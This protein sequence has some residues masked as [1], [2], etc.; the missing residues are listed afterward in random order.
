M[1]FLLS[2][3]PQHWRSLKRE[4]ENASLHSSGSRVR[5]P[6]VRSV[7]R[8]GSPQDRIQSSK[9]ESGSPS[10]RPSDMVRREWKYEAH[11]IKG[12]P[13]LASVCVSARARSTLHSIGETF[14]PP[15][16]RRSLRQTCNPRQ[17]L[18]QEVRGRTDGVRRA[19]VL[20]PRSIDD[21]GGREGGRERPF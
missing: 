16:S 17:R 13:K 7:L 14:A 9:W 8:A 12:L 2:H 19:A 15:P 18:K 5:L 3:L 21:E 11:L 6:R 10:V 20:N 1:L 4:C